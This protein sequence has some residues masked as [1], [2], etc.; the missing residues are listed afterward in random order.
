VKADGSFRL[1]GFGSFAKSKRAPKI[2]E[3]IE[4]AATILNIYRK[5]R[6][7]SPPPRLS[8]RG[9]GGGK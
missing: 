7:S 3:A 4:I 5:R 9:M 6:R 8:R 1:V 2:G